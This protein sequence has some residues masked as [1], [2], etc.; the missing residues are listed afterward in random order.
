MKATFKGNL[1]P[2]LLGEN[3][4]GTSKFQLPNGPIDDS[5]K[6]SLFVYIIDNSNE[7]SK[8]SIP[9]QIIVQPN[10]ALI[11][12]LAT[13]LLGANSNDYLNELKNASV[14]YTTTLITS[15]TSALDNQVAEANKVFN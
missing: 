2:I 13:K 10:V 4:N 5:Y 6:I 1:N 8:F 11:D 15:L 3:S 12:S 14:Q 9:T 7:F